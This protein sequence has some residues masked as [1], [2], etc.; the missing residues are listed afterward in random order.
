MTIHERLEAFWAG[1]RPDRIPYTIYQWE[2]RHIA[3]DSRLGP[4]YDA[5]LGVTRHV[6]VHT[7][8]TP[9]LEVVH[10]EVTVDGRP[11]HRATRRTPV[12]E[13][14]TLSEAGWC[15]KHWL[16]TPE[17][18]R[19][20]TWI[21]EN[22]RIEPHYDNWRQ[23][24]EQMGPW[25]VPLV[26]AGRTPM[27]TILVDLAGLENFAMHLYDMADAVQA[28]YDALLQQFRR[29]IEIVAGGPGR[30]VSVL[31]NFTAETMG[32]NRFREFLLPV[33]EELYPQL[34]AAGKIVGNHY[35][36]KIASCAE[37]IAASPIDLMESLTPPPEGDLTMAQ[38]RA[39]LPD[40]LF[41]ANVNVSH[42]AL[43]P[44][45]LRQV[46]LDMVT[47]G[48]VNGRKLALEVSEHLP[49]NWYDSMPVVLDALRETE[50]G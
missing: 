3:D 35:D 12:G 47:D 28:L 36:G 16:A 48:S 45:Q 43:P 24:V 19:V 15:Q 4:M 44:A 34:H 39:K 21:V 27:Q 20:M 2:W 32:P 49:A 5:G 8:S 33:Y 42:Y 40:K 18:Y 22:T 26:A 14:H 6:P 30:F 31:E 13:I 38:A 7:A 17:D 37:M 50:R 10:D 1:E 23:A 41:W 11:M 29:I 9:G 46:V 25:G